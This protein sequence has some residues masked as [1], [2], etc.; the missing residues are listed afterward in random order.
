MKKKVVL[1][2][3]YISFSGTDKVVQSFY[4]HLMNSDQYEPYILYRDGI[5]TER[6]SVVS[7][8]FNGKNLI[9]YTWIPGK[10]GKQHPYIPEESNFVDKLQEIKPDI[11]HVHNAGTAEWPC[12]KSLYPEAKW[13]NHSIFGYTD[14]QKYV[15]YSIYICNTIQELAINNHFGKSGSMLYNPIEQPLCTDTLAARSILINK[16][17]LPDNA[18]ILGRVGRAD[19]FTD[20]SL[21]AF[22]LIERQFP[23]VYYLVVN[24]C[25]QWTSFAKNNGIQNVRFVDTII[26]DLGM[27][28]FYSGIDVL[29]HARDDGECNS[30]VIGEAM[31][32]GVPV[33]THY[34]SGYNG[35]AESVAGVGF[36]VP[37]NDYFAYADVL[38]KLISDK[39]LLMEFSAKSRR[40]A[41]LFTEASFITSLLEKIYDHVLSNPQ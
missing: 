36:C 29:A 23:H 31:M 20:I 5:L 41:M 9:P 14:V 15:D 19:N 1:H 3:K 38:T 10:R 35:Q 11:V 34:T 32:H 27:S 12:F 2:S 22:Q 40:K 6:L 17:G 39:K 26:D 33:V 7:S 24:P 13:I 25:H 37:K 18:F 16:Y 4:R 8:W 21:K 30:V 28:Q